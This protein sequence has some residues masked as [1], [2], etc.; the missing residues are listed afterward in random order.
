MQTKPKVKLL[1]VTPLWIA[2]HAI[3]KSKDSY[4]KSDT[5]AWLQ[6]SECY[7]GR[8][9]PLV[10]ADKCPNCGSKHVST[11]IIIGNKDRELIYRIAN[12]YKHSSTIEHIIATFD[13]SNISRALLQELSR[14]RIASLTV[15]STRYTLKKLSDEEPFYLE[16]DWH[17]QTTDIGKRA[18]KYLVYSGVDR[19]D[20]HSIQALEN[21][22]QD[23]EAGVSN[24]IAKYTL[25]ESFKTSLIWTINFRSLQ[26]FLKLRTAPDALW[27][28]R[29]LAYAIF[30][31]IPD[32]Y[33]YLLEDFVYEKEK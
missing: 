22:R 3:R 15:K 32:E 14:H 30:D 11:N 31:A 10:E 26:N 1:H 9:V 24:D 25:P 23:I 19:V 5:K 4:D 18:E 29:N 6:C 20:W 27:E 28:I 12:K 7:L 8:Y 16:S 21:L 13:I 17:C 33:K 2:A